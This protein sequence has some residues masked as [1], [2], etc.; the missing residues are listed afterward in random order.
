[1]TKQF[2]DANGNTIK[3][4][5]IV[6]TLNDN[7]MRFAEDSFDFI[8]I[9][10]DVYEVCLDKQTRCYDGVDCIVGSTKVFKETRTNWNC[11]LCNKSLDVQT[12]VDYGHICLDCL[13]DMLVTD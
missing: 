8:C 1:M 7:V 13:H 3:Q 6:T 5:D 4:G 12:V 2:L 9:A 11:P 10:R